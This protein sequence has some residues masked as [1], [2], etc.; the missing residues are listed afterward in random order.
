[1][2]YL[3]YSYEKVNQITKA[4]DCFSKAVDIVDR[5][6]GDNH[7]FVAEIYN[8]WGGALE[9]MGKYDEAL[10]KFSR[11]LQIKH[12][13]L[14]FD[15]PSIGVTHNNL[16]LVYTKLADHKRAKENYLKAYDIW[17]HAYEAPNENIATALNNIGSAHDSL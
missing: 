6:Y 3:G 10:R 14:T 2:V 5:Y 1:M 9:C 15:H 16:G 12:R 11:C 13:V 8:A 4:C 7:P 17:S